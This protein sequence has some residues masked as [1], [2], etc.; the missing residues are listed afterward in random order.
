MKSAS[1][2]P[3]RVGV[4]SRIAQADRAV[5]D[6]VAAGFRKEEITVICPTCTPEKY[7]DY[8]RDDPAG[9][10]AATAAAGG[11]AIG[12]LLGG[13]VGTAVGVASGGTA[14]LVAG[15]L[16]SAMGGGAVAGGFIGAMMTRGME[17]EVA[18][19]YDQ[20]LEKGQ[21]L[22]AVETERDDDPRLAEAE[23]VLAR[24]GADPIPLPRG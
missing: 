16:L 23:R 10:H 22:V 8:H 9:A 11:S 15:P 3:V 21:I 6:L 12:A 7:Q 24:A 20:A 18:N 4:F 2:S 5:R 13:L 19:F 1:K 17:R 14:L